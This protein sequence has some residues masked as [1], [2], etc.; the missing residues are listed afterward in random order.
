MKYSLTVSDFA[1]PEMF[2]NLKKAI[3]E[4][5]PDFSFERT[6]KEEG[7]AETA[8][9]VCGDKHICAEINYATKKVQASSDIPVPELTEYF[10]LSKNAAKE[11]KKGLPDFPSPKIWKYIIIPAALLLLSVTAALIGS[12]PDLSFYS[13]ALPFQVSVLAAYIFAYTLGWI[14]FIPLLTAA[15]AAA[16]FKK[17]KLCKLIAA[18]VPLLGAARLCIAYPDMCE[19]IYRDITYIP[20]ALPYYGTGEVIS[21]LLATYVLVLPYMAANDISGAVCV[22]SGGKRPRKLFTALCWTVSAVVSITA[23]CATGIFTYMDYRREDEEY[24]REEAE[25]SA[26]RAEEKEQLTHEYERILNKYSEDMLAAAKYSVQHRYY[27]WYN[28]PEPSME[29]VW[30]RLFKSARPDNSKLKYRCTED[31]NYID[32]AIEDPNYEYH[33]QVFPD[34][35]RIVCG[36]EVNMLWRET[37]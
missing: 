29:A 24:R 8:L 23:V 37:E 6:I 35:N 32:I 33:F 18:A 3:T 21:L 7:G 5:Y 20:T 17:D 16:R 4:L 36:W 1:D 31:G 30:E 11:A 22:K 26:A 2:G 10:G 19:S 28:C 25:Y 9:Y 14:W 34:T 12:F 15:I 13:V 27:G